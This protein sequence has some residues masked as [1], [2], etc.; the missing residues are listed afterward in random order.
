MLAYRAFDEATMLRA[1]VR[2]G[3]VVRRG[4]AMYGNTDAAPAGGKG[5]AA[6]RAP[7]CLLLAVPTIS[8]GEAEYRM[9]EGK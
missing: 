2:G 5:R 4:H 9:M 6:R 8:T 3:A 1:A 7:V